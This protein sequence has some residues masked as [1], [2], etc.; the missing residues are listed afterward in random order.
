MDIAL[1]TTLAV[2]KW[3]FEAQSPI[4]VNGEEVVVAELSPLMGMGIPQFRNGDGVIVAIKRS[5]DV[6]PVV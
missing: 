1:A 2:I 5:D 4:L 6:R 3:G